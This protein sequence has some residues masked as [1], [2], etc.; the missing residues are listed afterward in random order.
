MPFNVR[1][2]RGQLSKKDYLN[3]LQQ[4]LAIFETIENIGI[5]HESLK[6]VSNV[7]LDIN[8]LI[9]EGINPS[10]TIKSTMEYIDHLKNKRYD[11][12]LQHIYLNYLALAYGGQM[13]K[14]N[15]PSKGKMYDFDN[16]QDAVATVRAVQKDDWAD[17]VNLGFDFLIR[18]FEELDQTQI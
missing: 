1:M 5:P 18:I 15:V 2:F 17:E 4:Q 12:I 10:K 16:L 9:Q 7:Q 14:K 6:R 8:E 3:Y 11:E 13:I